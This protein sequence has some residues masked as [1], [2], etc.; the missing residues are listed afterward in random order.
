MMEKKWRNIHISSLVLCG[1][2]YGLVNTIRTVVRIFRKSLVKNDDVLQLLVI[3]EHG[4]KLKLILDY[5]TMWSS[6]VPVLE[7]FMV[8]EKLVK[9]ALIQLDGSFPFNV[10]EI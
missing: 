4:K 8:L 7:K 1:N 10:F 9:T 2:V 3:K 6:L 5:K